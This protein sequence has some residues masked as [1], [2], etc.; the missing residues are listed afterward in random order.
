[1]LERAIRFTSR[2][3]RHDRTFAKEK[4]PASS[5]FDTTQWQFERVTQFFGEHRDAENNNR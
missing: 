5:S 2:A 4:T 3:P 1:M